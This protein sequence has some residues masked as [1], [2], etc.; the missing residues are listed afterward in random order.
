MSTFRAVFVLTGVLAVV[1]VPAF[2]GFVATPEPKLGILTAIGL[3]GVV[4]VANKLK[5]R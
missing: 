5:K 2:A 4:L 3:G 1:C